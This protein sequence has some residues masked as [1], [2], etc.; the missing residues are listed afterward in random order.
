MAYYMI[1]AAYTSEAVA[2]LIRRPQDR[3]GSLRPMFKKLGGSLEGAWFAFGDYDVVL[4]A[5]MPNNVTTAALALAVAAGGALRTMKT[6][7]LLTAKE[8]VAAMRKA[9]AAGYKPPK[10]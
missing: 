2:K 9:S 4:I 7:P 10:G 8:G 6:T 3:L 5:E 1:Q